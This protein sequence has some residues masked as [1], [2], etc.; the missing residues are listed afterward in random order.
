MVGEPGGDE[1]KGWGQDEDMRIFGFRKIA[2]GRLCRGEGT[3]H[4]H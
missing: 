2:M 1:I 4:V 3:T